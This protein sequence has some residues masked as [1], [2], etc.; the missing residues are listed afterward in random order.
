MR[1]HIRVIH[2]RIRSILRNTGLT[3]QGSAT[4]DEADVAQLGY[5]LS[6]TTDATF[7]EAQASVLALTRVVTVLGLGVGE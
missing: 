3:A 7:E 1:I 5:L 2:R 4:R 6:E